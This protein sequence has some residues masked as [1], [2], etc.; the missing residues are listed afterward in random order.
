MSDYPEAV[1]VAAQLM[2]IAALTAPKGRGQDYVRTLVLTGDDVRKLGEATIAYGEKTGKGNFDRDGKNTIAS[3]A[4]LLIGLVA[5]PGAG[6][7][8]GA[9]GYANCKEFNAAQKMTVEFTG[10][11]CPVRVLDM[12]IAL[13]SA[14]KTASLLNVDNRVMYR[15]GVAAREMGLVDWDFVMGIPINVSAKNIYFDR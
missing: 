6:V 15:I 13:G 5:A 1:A 12:G 8:C 2:A 10:P 7:D 11:N 3:E 4:V 9:C 14:A